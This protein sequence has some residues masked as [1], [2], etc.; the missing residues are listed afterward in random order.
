M[1]LSSHDGR[2][3]YQSELKLNFERDKELILGAWLVLLP[4]HGLQ[5][6]LKI[7]RKDEQG[8][9]LDTEG[10]KITFERL[11]GKGPL[12]VGEEGERG[13]IIPSSPLFF[14]PPF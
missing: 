14:F 4:C 10:A 6:S 1:R 13:G 11:F 3:T 2:C 12:D 8:K 9:S 5:W 7:S